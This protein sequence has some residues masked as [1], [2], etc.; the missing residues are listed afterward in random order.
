[1]IIYIDNYR[2]LGKKDKDVVDK[3]QQNKHTKSDLF[4]I[5][6]VINH[7]TDQNF[8]DCFCGGYADLEEQFQ[9][10]IKKAQE[11]DENRIK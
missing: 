10:I 1:M 11:Y 4:R 5:Q 3:F 7:I 9:Q 6:R 2:D 8:T